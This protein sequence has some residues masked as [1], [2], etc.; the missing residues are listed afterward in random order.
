[1]QNLYLIQKKWNYYISEL[2]PQQYILQFPLAP[3]VLLLLLFLLVLLFLPV[4]LLLHKITLLV[5]M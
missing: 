4:L 5:K 3:Q 1:M 2:W